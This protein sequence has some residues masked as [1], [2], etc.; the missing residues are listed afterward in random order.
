MANTVDHEIVQQGGINYVFT[1]SGCGAVIMGQIVNSAD[2]DVI[3]RLNERFPHL[4]RINIYDKSITVPCAN[5][6]G[7]FAFKRCRP[8]QMC[9][10]L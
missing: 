1:C 7:R 4:D 2:A 8:R 9:V 3:S 5:R 6:S 10:S